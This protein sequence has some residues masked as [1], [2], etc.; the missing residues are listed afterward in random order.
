[1]KFQLRGRN[2]SLGMIILIILGMV[3]VGC[4]SNA[5][6]TTASCSFVIGDG[7]DGRDA[8][9]HKVVYTGQTFS[10]KDEKILYFPCNPRT[11]QINDGSIEV[12][13]GRVVGDRLNLTKAWTK[14]GIPI[15]IALTA[16]WTLNQNEDALRNFFNVCFKFTCADS[17]DIGGSANFSTDGW[18]G[19]L[20]ET[21]SPVLDRLAREAAKYVDDSIWSTHDLSQNEAMETY[22]ST[23]FAD[24]FRK[25]V[26]YPQNLLCGSGNSQWPNPDKP[27]EGEFQCSDVRIV[28][29]GVRRVQTDTDESADGAKAIN[30]LRLENAQALYGPNAGHWLGLIDAI[31]QCKDSGSTCV[32]NIGGG[33]ST[34]VPIPSV[35]STPAPMPSVDASIPPQ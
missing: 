6:T 5:A 26:G 11:Y 31:A 17:Q 22:M 27:G 25:V 28:V 24:E 4:S 12:N 33:T 30:E 3:L 14:K 9:L 18:N 1:M 23:N 2:I 29:D 34:S 8:R 15:E 13:G 10:A 21:I 19:M 32:F 35:A 20:S 16:Y 7:Q